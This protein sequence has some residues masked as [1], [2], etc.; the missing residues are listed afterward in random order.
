MFE[1]LT[2][3]HF[4]LTHLWVLDLF[5]LKCTIKL[6]TYSVGFQYTRIKVW[7]YQPTTEYP[8]VCRD[9]LKFFIQMYSK[10]CV[11]QN[12]HVAPQ[13][14]TC[15]Y[16]NAQFRNQDDWKPY[17]EYNTSFLCIMIYFGNK[18]HPLNTPKG[19]RLGGWKPKNTNLRILK[20]PQRTFHKGGG[21]KMEVWSGL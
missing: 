11:Q 1:I 8:W 19:T 9:G 13:G 17:P 15:D 12:R 5:D 10:F 16:F 20:P 7:S 6:E 3:S 4:C 2:V 14:Y 21:L 18:F